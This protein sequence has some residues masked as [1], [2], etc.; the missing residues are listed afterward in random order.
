MDCLKKLLSSK[1][2][3]YFKNCC[4]FI[5]NFL[6]HAT[7]VLND[8]RLI[9]SCADVADHY[10][11]VAHEDCRFNAAF[12]MD[13]FID[14]I[15]LI[16]EEICKTLKK[17]LHRRIRD[18]KPA[19]RALIVLVSRRFQDDKNIQDALIWHFYNDPELAVRKNLL[20][21]MDLK[22]FGPN[23]LVDAT[24]DC[25]EAI[26]KTAYVRLSKVKPSEL[27]L[28]Q[29]HRIMHNGLLERERQVSYSFK[30]NTFEHWLEEMYDGLDMIKLIE[31]FDIINH[32]EDMSRMLTLVHERDLDKIEN[33]GTATKLH[34]VV[35]GFRERWLRNKILPNP[36]ELDER[37]I[38]VWISLVSFCR[39]NSQHI[40]PVKIRTIQLA[41]GKPDESL[42][43]ILDSQEQ[44][45]DE[46]IELFE[47]I[48]PDLVNLIDFLKKFVRHVDHVVKSDKT[49]V[50]N[51]EFIYHKLMDFIMS[52]EIGDELERRT[53]QEALGFMLRENLLT[54]H[55]TNYIPPI[56][57]CLHRLIYYK[58]PNL[59]LNYIS[60]LI[61][62]IRSHLEDLAAPTQSSQV[63][64]SP[65]PAS[66][67]APRSAKKVTIN[68]KLPTRQSLATKAEE[69]NL[70][71]TIATKRVEIEELRDQFEECAKK[72][73][74]DQVKSIIH[75][76]ENLQAEINLLSSRRYSIAS[77]VSHMSLD[78]DDEPDNKLSST[79]LAPD[80]APAEEDRA[81]PVSK[82]DPKIFKHHAD[83]L[84]K[85]LQ[86]YYACLECV[87]VKEVPP[88]MCN[89]LSHLSYESLDEW[90]KNNIRVRSL[91]IA[92][93]GITALM[94]KNFAKLD[95]TTT[96][97]V[98]ACY[99]STSC[100][101]IKTIGFKSLVDVSIEHDEVQEFSNKIEKFLDRVLQ[102]YGKYNPKEIRDNELEFLNTII[103][104]TA[105][106]FYH[107]KL[108]SPAIFS[109]L[110]IWWYHPDTPSKL[111]QFIGVFLPLFV[112]DM[113]LQR[114]SSDDHWL[115]N[116]LSET[117]VTSMESLHD[118]ILES[119]TMA[120]GDMNNLI[121][122]LCNLVPISFHPRV[123]NVVDKRIDDVG[124][125][126]SDLIR[127]LKQSKKSL[128][129]AEAAS[130]IR[131][132]ST[133]PVNDTRDPIVMPLKLFD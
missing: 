55:F 107:K 129:A 37:V 94:D 119:D 3:I 6:Q 13:K 106:L 61:Q 86:M 60:E 102:D 38:T 21:T 12:F 58:S 133:E 101:E 89:H 16:D 22:I 73:D 17:T 124:N 88:I 79:M 25:F 132:K 34:H 47:R 80:D 23:F 15:E 122:F 68:D 115:E 42:E 33:N 41:T 85:C 20:K 112:K 69:E 76:I 117:F 104:G 72:M 19:I 9:R 32:Q 29:I 113:S 82:D 43:R 127:F 11:Q 130:F 71:Y 126:N 30:T 105:K 52:Y 62:N 125:R 131:P 81:S 120:E 63:F 39:K 92:C 10:L 110:I 67:K 111:T 56:I 128:A 36:E 100:L 14:K 121:N 5:C 64:Q 45:N 7:T 93:N 118:H 108:D 31:H 99:D 40:K 28:E 103:E 66:S 78:L 46:V 1:Y 44:G 96:L 109:H 48:N 8:D 65:I 26:R 114:T 50:K 83:E 98:S 75:K 4:E 57:R 53:V 70:D 35:E 24:Q 91:M 116:L 74:C 77:D 87:K 97:F 90:F 54:C 95:R 59:M 84:V 2:T 49:R 27:N 51:Y 18:K 123:H